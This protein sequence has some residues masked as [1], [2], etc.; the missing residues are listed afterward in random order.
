MCGRWEQDTPP[1][2]N[3]DRLRQNKNKELERLSQ[4]YMKQIET[5]GIKYV[6]GR[7]H[8]VD[9]HTVEVNGEKFTVRSRSPHTAPIFSGV[10]DKNKRCSC[11]NQGLVTDFYTAAP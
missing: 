4:V 2:L 8:V 3:W 11:L 10:W 5:A 1:R 6:E 9:A 7:G